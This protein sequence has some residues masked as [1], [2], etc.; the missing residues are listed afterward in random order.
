M[1]WLIK[2][3]RLLD[4]GRGIDQVADLLIEEGK[5]AKI[6]PGLVIEGDHETIEAKGMVLS[7]SFIDIHVHLREPG[8][9]HAEDIET[10]AR[11]AAA[12]GF[13]R[14]CCMPNS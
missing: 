11:A 10:G 12:G 6:G 3:A 13:S 1:R 5:I 2:E 8:M 9:T 14:I 4:P 7:P